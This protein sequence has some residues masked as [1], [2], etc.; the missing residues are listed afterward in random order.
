MGSKKLLIP[1]VLVF[2]IVLFVGFTIFGDNGVLHLVGMNQEIERINNTIERLH[3][4]NDRLKHIA[5]LLQRND[6]YQEMMARQELGMIR[7][8][9]KIFIFK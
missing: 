1:A 5:L 4:E 6:R 9:E 2:F 8:D 7:K 3:A